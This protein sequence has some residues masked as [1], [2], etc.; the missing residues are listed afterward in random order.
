MLQDCFLCD[1]LPLVIVPWLDFCVSTMLA[2]KLLGNSAV[3]KQQCALRVCRFVS[4]PFLHVFLHN[5]FSCS[6]PLAGASRATKASYIAILTTP[7]FLATRQ[8]RFHVLLRGKSRSARPYK[9]LRMIDFPTPPGQAGY[10]N[11]LS[12]PHTGDQN[13]N[14]C[15]YIYIFIIKAT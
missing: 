9:R 13:E 15:L 5:S 4:H 12:L 6:L 14:Y 3:R 7:Q 1:V 11:P 10:G 8:R 2:G